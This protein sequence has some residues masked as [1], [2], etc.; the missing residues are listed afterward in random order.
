MKLAYELKDG[1]GSMFPNERKEAD[2]HADWRGT[3]KIDGKEYWVN[4]WNKQGKTEF[5]SLSV[6]PKEARKASSGHK[7]PSK[8]DRELPSFDKDLDDSIPF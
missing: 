1:Q 8:S 4:G 5:I 3:I 2:T 6:K 7:P